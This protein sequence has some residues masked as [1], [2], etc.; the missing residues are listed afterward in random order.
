MVGSCRQYQQW[1][2]GSSSGGSSINGW[3][4]Q[5]QQIVVVVLIVVIKAKLQLRTLTS[6]LQTHT[7]TQVLK[8]MHAHFLIKLQ[9]YSQA[10]MRQG[11]GR[12]STHLRQLEHDRC[13]KTG[14]A[15]GRAGGKVA[16][17]L[18][19]SV[20]IVGH[21]NALLHRVDRLGPALKHLLHITLHGKT[22]D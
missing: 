10:Q 18:R 14:A 16:Q 19:I 8:R 22:K 3:Q 6:R 1:C 2:G 11:Q 12:V 5:M 20:P 13:P 21:L 17:V 15:V 4:Q 9:A 7:V